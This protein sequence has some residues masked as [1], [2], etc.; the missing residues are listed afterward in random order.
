MQEVCQKPV[1]DLLLINQVPLAFDVRFR[2]V[3][4]SNVLPFWHLQKIVFLKFSVEGS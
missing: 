2:C 4:L 3:N 1:M